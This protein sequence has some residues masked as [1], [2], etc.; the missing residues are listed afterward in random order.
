MD[1]GTEMT[2]WE[3]TE[4]L[5]RLPHASNTTLLARTNDGL[6]VYKPARGEA[7]LWD[8]EHGTLAAREVLTYEVAHAAEWDIVPET[9]L[10]EGPFGLGSVQRFIE[11][12]FEFD[13]VEMINNGYHQLWSTAVLDILINNADRKAGHVIEE[14]ESGHLY[15]I[16][17]GVSFH[18][19][20]KLR[21]VLWAFAERPLPDEMVAAVES[22]ETAMTNG[23]HGR[24][25][26]LLSTAE[27][28]ATAERVATLLANPVHPPPPTD[29]PPVPW[30]VW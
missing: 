16:D 19:D 9:A 18:K 8:F 28:D 24:I 20:P 14:A 11:E 12:N 6:V 2:L 29:R 3:I 23:L 22:V 1:T 30:P 17:H 13:P 21:T 25:A 4:V 10:V 7:P 15:C 26:E 5:G 27:A